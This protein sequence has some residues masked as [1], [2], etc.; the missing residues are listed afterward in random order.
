ML[1]PEVIRA[2]AG[3]IRSGKVYSLGLPVQSTGVP[4]VPYRGVPM[5]LTLVNQ[6][7]TGIYDAY[8]AVD[9]GANEDVLVLASHNETHMDA[10]CH[11]HHHDTL[12]NGFSNAT[13]KTHTGAGRCG[14]EKTPWVVGRAVLLDVAGYHGVECL[15]VP[16][17][18]TA[19]ELLAVAAAQGVELQAGDILL[20]R[21]GWV[22]SF[23]ANPTVEIGGQPGIG[24][25]A[26]RLIVS[27]DLAAVGADNSAVEAMPFDNDEFLSV[28]IELLVKRG[29]PLLEHLVLDEMAADKAYETFLVVAP[30][31]ITGGTGS[32]INPIAIA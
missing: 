13:M 6:A 8:G 4:L 30:L 24:L 23:M 14:I 22:G 25:D 1:T 18:I 11:V 29:L 17:I 5:R 26:C 28:H 16:H 20:I 21:T 31:P 3:S 7:D 15:A 2:A 27:L 10:L 9:V 32:P 19:D 12:Y